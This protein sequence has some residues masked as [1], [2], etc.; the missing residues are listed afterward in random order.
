MIRRAIR[1]SPDAF[2]VVAGC[3]AEVNADNLTKINGVDLILGSNAK[4]SLFEHLD[5]LQKKDSPEVYI[6]RLDER[7]EFKSPLSGHFFQHTRAFL[8]IQ[9]GCD[10]FCSYCIVPYARGRTRSGKPKQI[11]Q[12]AQEL[13][14]KGYREI[15]LTGAHIGYYG[16]DQTPPVKLVDLMRQLEKIDGLDRIRLSSIEPL[17]VTPELI[18]FI[19]NSEKMCP[20]LHIP[21]QSGDPEILRAMNRHYTPDEYKMLIDS[22]IQKIPNIAIG[23]DVMVG[24]PSE[25]DQQAENTFQFINSL[26]VSYLHIFSYSVRKG[27]AAASLPNRV[28]DNIKKLRSRRLHSLGSDKKRTFYHCFLGKIVHVLFEQIDS[29]Q[30]VSGLSENYIRLKVAGDESLINQ[31][32]PVSITQVDDGFVKGKIVTGEPT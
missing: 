10:A 22:L 29:E 5:G 16:K 9:D 18:N 25:T 14:Q 28:P 31:I 19:A 15:V 32:V 2:I 3:Y 26:P 1:T 7:P 13:V 12:Q 21:L 4:F 17:E 6:D 20:H 8:K 11:I 30:L 24:F 27:T 23:T